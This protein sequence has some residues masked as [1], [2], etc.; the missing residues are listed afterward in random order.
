MWDVDGAS[1]EWWRAPS[2][3]LKYIGDGAL[4][5]VSGTGEIHCLAGLPI[6]DAVHGMA[7][8]LATIDELPGNRYNLLVALT[9][10]TG[11]CLIAQ[12][13]R[14]DDEASEDS[15]ISLIARVSGV[16]TVI[17]SKAVSSPGA[18]VQW[19]R[20]IHAKWIAEDEVFCV[21][22]APAGSL[23]WPVIA[24]PI[25]FAEAGVTFTGGR[26]S[27]IGNA[28]GDAE[29]PI[30]VDDFAIL[31]LYETEEEKNPCYGC[32]CYCEEYDTTV[33]PHELK[34]QTLF[35]HKLNLH[36]EGQ[37]CDEPEIFPCDTTG[38]YDVIDEVVE[39]IHVPVGEEPADSCEDPPGCGTCETLTTQPEQFWFNCIPLEICGVEFLFTFW[40]N[41]SLQVFYRLPPETIWTEVSE[42][43]MREDYTCYPLS[44]VFDLYIG[45]I[46][47]FPCCV[48]AGPDCLAGSVGSYTFT[49]TEA[50]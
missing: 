20:S 24:M 40:C 26:F 45:P 6:A 41:P 23:L 29:L 19:G 9:P 3:Q 17:K 25:D 12:W 43:I 39:L 13:Y 28:S 22:I 36:M 30:E 38:C 47:T 1:G 27:G 11:D 49:I 46:N 42:I 31:R 7:A 48:P 37:C 4:F 2:T 16:E 10:E 32:I 18:N 15:V 33:E 14:G 21:S 44:I 8:Y 50:P 35:P 34:W 5:E